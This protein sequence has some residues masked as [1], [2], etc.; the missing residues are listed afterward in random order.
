[1]N[2]W[3]KKNEISHAHAVRLQA[4]LDLANKEKDKLTESEKEKIAAF[5]NEHTKYLEEHKS[6]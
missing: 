3:I 6:E 1:M 2:K 4:L 5:E